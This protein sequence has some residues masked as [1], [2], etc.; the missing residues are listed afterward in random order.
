MIGGLDRWLGVTCQA[1]AIA[2]SRTQLLRGKGGD[3]YKE[4]CKGVHL[5]G[6][7]LHILGLRNGCLWIAGSLQRLDVFC[8]QHNIVAVCGGLQGSG[9]V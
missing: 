6:K 5:E 8:Q 7:I 1:T 2:M 4:Q 3:L 9:T